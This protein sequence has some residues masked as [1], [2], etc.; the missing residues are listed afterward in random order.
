MT[1]LAE[2]VR[3]VLDAYGTPVQRSRFFSDLVA[4]ALRRDR[5]VAS[6]ETLTNAHTSVAAAQESG[7]LS[8]IAW[9]QFMCGFACL[10]HGDLDEAEHQL[11]SAL[12]LTEQTGD[13][14]VQ[15]RC[16]TYLTI[17]NRKR[18]QIEKVR[19]TAARSLA[20]ATTGKMPEYISMAKANLAWVA[21]RQG[22][23]VE[24][25]ELGQAAFDLFR[26]TVQGQ[27]LPWV[28]LWPLIGTRLAQNQIAEA[29]EYVRGLF[30]S[31]GQLPPDTLVS[32]LEASIQSWEGGQ[33]EKT[34]AYLI[35]AS[36]LAQQM[37]YL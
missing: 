29:I 22:N 10:W 28:V 20:V 27:M 15:S 1:L 6:E 17:T 9:A 26:Q 5:Y 33:P 7:N 32:V 35:E 25:Q 16:L 24:A 34:Y 37:G 23:L 31:T 14:T 18:G 19:D 13:V 21:R 4:L 12:E 2:K 8:E 36:E 11:K 30:T 3:P